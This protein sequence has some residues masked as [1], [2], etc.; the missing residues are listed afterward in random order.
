MVNE[1][2]F[3]F[4]E[5][6]T[7]TSGGSVL[8]HSGVADPSRTKEN[9]AGL[10]SFQRWNTKATPPGNTEN[11]IEAC[12]LNGI[13]RMIPQ[14]FICLSYAHVCS[15]EFRTQ[16][17]KIARAHGG[18]SNS[19]DH[20]LWIYPDS[21]IYVLCTG[22]VLYKSFIG[23]RTLISWSMALVFYLWY[24]LRRLCPLGDNEN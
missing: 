18:C 14:H 3:F 15:A 7:C 10:D 23:S 12:V 19:K 13:K 8:N 1:I 9:T 4:A 16:S 21:V 5:V 2:I 20:G 24:T 6:S 22:L 17:W 11:F